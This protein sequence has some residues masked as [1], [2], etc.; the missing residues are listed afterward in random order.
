MAHDWQVEVDNVDGT[1]VTD[2]I[3]CRTAKGEGVSV[4]V[5]KDMIHEDPVEFSMRI[6]ETFDR[7][8]ARLG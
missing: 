2:A 3:K 4:E 1:L 7:K 8:E 6:A 5:A